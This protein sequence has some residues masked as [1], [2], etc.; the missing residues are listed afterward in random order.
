MVY[1]VTTRTDHI[2]KCPYKLGR[3]AAIS[4][5]RKIQA[6]GKMLAVDIE[7]NGLD[8]FTSDILL[9]TIGDYNT[10]V[11]FDAT[12]IDLNFLYEFLSTASNSVIGHNLKFDY[13]FIKHHLELDI[14]FIYDTMIV[15]QILSQ[16]DKSRRNNLEA[17]IARR[18]QRVLSIPKSTR[19][20]FINMDLK[21]VFDT[22][23]VMYA[24]ED[25]K[26]L[27]AI[28]TAQI[29]FITRAR[30]ELRVGIEMQLV[31]IIANMEL[32][33]ILLNTTAWKDNI[34]INTVELARYQSLLDKELCDIA[35]NRSMD[36]KKYISVRGGAVFN[37][38]DLF[39]GNKKIIVASTTHVNFGSEKQVKQVFRDFGQPV[40]MDKHSK[41]SIGREILQ[42]YNVLNYNGLLSTFIDQ[43][44]V[45]VK[46]RKKLSSF[47]E[48]FLDMINP[49]TGAIHTIYK[50]CSTV[51]GRFAS[52]DTK[53]GH[54]NMAQIPKDNQY[55]IPFKARVGYKLMTIDFSACE[56]TILASMSKDKTL[57]RLLMDDTADLHSYLANAAWRKVKKDPTYTVTDKER[58]IFK[59]VNFGLVYG[60]TPIRIAALLNI[61]F[62]DAKLVVEALT[63][64]IPQAFN[65]LRKIELKALKDGYIIFNK[66]TNSRR[67]FKEVLS[68]KNGGYPVPYKL[69]GVIG[70]AAKN[71]PI[72][73][74]NADLMKESMVEVDK[75]IK[76]TNIDAHI[77]L[78]VYDE[79]VIEIP[80]DVHIFKI[81][82]KIQDIMEITADKYL[83][84]TLG[85]HM[86]SNYK[87][88][89]TWQK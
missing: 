26:N 1:F 4:L 87:I 89:N 72:Q 32:R 21:S 9:L 42:Q 8:P 55:R 52:G 81:A 40:P 14:T 75:Y 44:L 59:G 57:I 43:L 61:S 63:N 71:A 12:S 88:A 68:A 20:E 47:G 19:L 50:Q 65:Y 10:Q 85:I 34:K 67:V 16:G 56:L 77:L 49:V 6:Q 83:D 11:V 13:K 31:P 45:F 51:T 64:E 25:I 37:V 33:G 29:P 62:D 53:N 17:V 38:P 78:Q 58:T 24:A 84:T 27:Q 23:H 48:N 69:Y 2:Y 70:R 74:T 79:L 82:E 86:K 39:T 15:E 41:V 76:A 18:L 73:G 5:L 30:L 66:R 60:A 22:R 35:I 80:D 28:R 36:D 3:G 46:I 7:T 54:P